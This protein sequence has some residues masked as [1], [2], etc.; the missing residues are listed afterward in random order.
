MKTST[1]LQDK[2]IL[3]NPGD[4]V[5]TARVEIDAGTVL[6]RDVGDDIILREKIPFGHKLSLESI[7]TGEPVLKYG[8]R[9]GV[10]TSNIDAGELVHVHNLAG[11]RG[12]GK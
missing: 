3:A 7:T 10:A 9:I 8:H 12:K 5:A 4:N 1:K 11:E 2:A 6:S